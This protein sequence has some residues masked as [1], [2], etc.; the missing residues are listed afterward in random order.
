[1]AGSVSS[2]FFVPEVLADAM[3]GALAGRL[4]LDGT[5]AFNI[6]DG[7]PGSERAGNTINIPYFGH[8]GEL[9]S[10]T[11][12]QALTV[13]TLTSTA[14]TST[15][16]RAG[17]AFEITNWAQRAAAGDPYSEGARQMADSVIR[18]FDRAA[19]TAALATNLTLDR[20][21]A[22]LA[23]THFVELLDLFGDE[24]E[25][26]VGFAM[27][28][29]ILA[30][31]RGIKDT[32]G[33][34]IFVDARAD[35]RPTVFGLPVFVSDRNTVTADGGGTGV[36]TYKTIALKRGAGVIWRADGPRVDTDKDIL[37]DSKVASVNLYYAVHLY[38]K[39]PGNT[40]IGAAVIETRA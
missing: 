27:H 23:Y 17:K 37:A 20:K 19:L 8:I 30:S 35:G 25:D 36:D 9:E 3:A 7:L 1:M 6:V 11:D 5:G 22:A 24:Q 18:Q 28:S 34:L 15:V 4:A 16:V 31:L 13:A 10:R 39:Y 21:S 2:D 14:E 40:K 26:V 32:S 12:G 38:K 29:K 33:R